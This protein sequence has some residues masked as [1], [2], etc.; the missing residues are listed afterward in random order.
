M[1]TLWV[2]EANQKLQAKSYEP[3]RWN[4]FEKTGCL[5]TNDGSNDEKI[6]PEGLTGYK[7]LP[8][9]A[10]S[11]P[12]EYS[13]TEAPEPDEDPADEIEYEDLEMPPN[14]SD[15][16]VMVE[17]D[18]TRRVDHKKDRSYKEILVG[19]KIRGFYED[20]WQSGTIDYFN[21]NFQQYHIE[22]EDSSEDDYVK[23]SDINGVDMILI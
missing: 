2:G 16:E 18:P 21:K 7:V 6:K 11:G 14:H 9:F 4:C 17:N 23:M 15:P 5:I 20:G 19:R 13:D 12:V 22:F 3:F 8:P 10:T 1:I